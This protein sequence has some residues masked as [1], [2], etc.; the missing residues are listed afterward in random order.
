[1]TAPE[2]CIL[3]APHPA[4]VALRHVIGHMIPDTVYGALDQLLPGIVPAEGAGSLCNF[5]VSLRPRTDE[6][7]PPD[8]RFSE[9]L[10]FNSGGAG[11]RPGLTA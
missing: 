4:P 2:G 1:M 11:A 8:A 7:A 10:T 9:V 5:Q 6:P 3:N